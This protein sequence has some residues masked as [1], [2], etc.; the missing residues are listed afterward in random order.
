MLTRRE[1]LLQLKRAGVTGASQMK[2][3]LR[4][5]EK[6]LRESHAVMIAE[7]GGNLKEGESNLPSRSRSIGKGAMLSLLPRPDQRQN[8]F[9][10]EIQ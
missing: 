7:G 9:H 6:Y 8:F 1:V 2:I 4:D 3:Y 10:M 5:F